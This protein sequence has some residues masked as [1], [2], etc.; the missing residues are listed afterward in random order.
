VA[1]PM[2]VEAP[3]TMKNASAILGSLKNGKTK[4]I[5]LS[6]AKHLPID[7]TFS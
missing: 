4:A 2:P 5:D 1:R 3:V 6:L 7:K